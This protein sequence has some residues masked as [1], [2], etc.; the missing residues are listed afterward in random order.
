[1]VQRIAPY[2]PEEPLP[3][4][5]GQSKGPCRPTPTRKSKPRLTRKEV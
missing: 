4:F 3:G 2:D 5:R 1:M